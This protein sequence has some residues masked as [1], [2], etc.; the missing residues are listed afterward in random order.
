MAAFRSD[1]RRNARLGAAR[2]RYGFAGIPRVSG[3]VKRE[4]SSTAAHTYRRIPHLV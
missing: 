4:E 2:V 3:R 1:A